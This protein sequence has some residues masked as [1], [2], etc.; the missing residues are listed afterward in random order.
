MTDTTFSILGDSISTFCAY[1]P[2]ENEI[3]Y[4]KEGVDV[5]KV[6]HTWW[7]IL[8]ERTGLKL[9][10]NESYSGSRVSYTGSRPASSCFLSEKRQSRLKGD[11][12]IVFGGTNDWGQLEQP[13]T[14][15]IFQASYE[16]L[17]DSMERRHGGSKLYFCTP[18]QRTDRSL[19]TMNA[20][21]WNQQML[22]TIIKETV[23]RHTNARLIDLFS[24]TIKEGDGNLCDGLHP[25]RKGMQLIASWIQQGLGL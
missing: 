10:A 23:M 19:E 18:L 21:G 7:H 1:V 15:Q 13:T 22:N 2:Q 5:T 8:G 17:V 24:H 4:P 14:K 9:I 12:I 3:Y 25:T 11:I 20:Q 6:E 16:E